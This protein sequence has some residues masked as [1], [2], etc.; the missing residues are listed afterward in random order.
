MSHEYLCRN[1]PGG[2]RGTTCWLGACAAYRRSKLSF[3]IKHL[4]VIFNSISRVCDSFD[5]SHGNLPSDVCISTRTH[6][7]LHIIKN[8]KNKSFTILLDLSQNPWKT[9][10]KAQRNVLLPEQ[11]KAILTCT[12]LIFPFLNPQVKHTP[13]YWNYWLDNSLPKPPSTLTGM[14]VAISSNTVIQKLSLCRVWNRVQFWLDI[15]CITALQIRVGGNHQGDAGQLQEWLTLAMHGL[16]RRWQQLLTLQHRQ[17]WLSQALWVIVYIPGSLQP[18]T[19]CRKGEP[20]VLRN[21]PRKDTMGYSEVLPGDHGSNWKPR[22][23]AESVRELW[24]YPPCSS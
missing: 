21:L 23:W 22:N 17:E 20:K 12:L 16:S 3:H 2:T 7:H 24:T 5:H 8:N 14:A 6:T 11:Q 9:K 13:K 18:H 15:L 1:I 4:T 10:E 19:V